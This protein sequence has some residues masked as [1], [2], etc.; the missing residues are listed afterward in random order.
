MR[1]YSLL[2]NYA[3]Y[4]P[5]LILTDCKGQ[6]FRVK[7]GLARTVSLVATRPPLH[8]SWILLDSLFL[9]VS[10]LLSTIVKSCICVAYL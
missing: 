4:G 8:K 1:A 10:N 7:C 3:P 5:S 6:A 2:V 9:L